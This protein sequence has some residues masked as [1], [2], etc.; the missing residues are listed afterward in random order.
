MIFLEHE[1]KERLKK[2]KIEKMKRP[3]PNKQNRNQLL[4]KFMRHLAA[5][6]LLFLVEN[7]PFCM[8]SLPFNVSETLLIPEHILLTYPSCS[9]INTAFW[10]IST[11]LLNFKKM[12][13]YI[14]CSIARGFALRSLSV[15][16][17]QGQKLS[18]SNLILQKR[19]NVGRNETKL[20]VR[21]AMKFLH[22]NYPILEIH[23]M[24]DFGLSLG[25]FICNVYAFWEL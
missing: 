25:W 3:L 8:L 14:S 4:L 24:F 9:S 2:Q 1:T 12:I 13:R 6:V 22:E 15:G 7:Q 17:R 16:P 18:K 10:F 5:T 20:S 23:R 19:F 11:K 21:T